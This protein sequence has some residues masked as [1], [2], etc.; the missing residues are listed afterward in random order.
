[1]DIA[2]LLYKDLAFYW[3]DVSRTSDNVLLANLLLRV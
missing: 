2:T 3:L 1:M